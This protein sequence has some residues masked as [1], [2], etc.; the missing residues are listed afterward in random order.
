MHLHPKLEISTTFKS[1]LHYLLAIYVL[2][3]ILSSNKI[4]LHGPDRNIKEVD[5]E[6]NNGYQ[7]AKHD[8]VTPIDVAM[9]A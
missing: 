8:G 5:A 3:S 9:T 4:Q 6:T 1:N 2:I 7:L